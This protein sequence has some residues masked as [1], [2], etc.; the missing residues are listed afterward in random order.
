MIA[1]NRRTGSRILGTAEEL[2]ARANTDPG[3]FKRNS[4]GDLEYEHEGYTEV[5]W[6]GQKTATRAGRDRLPRRER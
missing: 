1:R 6:N 5:F 4:D 3:L 2:H